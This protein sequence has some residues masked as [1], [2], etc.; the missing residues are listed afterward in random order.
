MAVD[1]EWNPFAHAVNLRSAY[2]QKNSTV[3]ILNI[4][5]INIT[6]QQIAQIKLINGVMEFPVMRKQCRAVHK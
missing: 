2:P 4:I 6:I 3:L 1:R 5:T